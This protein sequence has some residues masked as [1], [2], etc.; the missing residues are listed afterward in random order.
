MAR[1]N[2]KSHSKSGS[3]RRTSSFSQ[4]GPQDVVGVLVD[5]RIKRR[6]PGAANGAVGIGEML[7]QGVFFGRILGLDGRSGQ[8]KKQ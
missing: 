2:R 5:E 6:I 7:D 1:S 8:K 3:T 4:G